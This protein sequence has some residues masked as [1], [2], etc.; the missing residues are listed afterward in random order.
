VPL[1]DRAQVDRWR[2]WETLLGPFA[3]CDRLSLMSART[4]SSF[5]L[6]L[7]GCR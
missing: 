1:V 4:P 2:D 5:R 6:R 3:S 7:H